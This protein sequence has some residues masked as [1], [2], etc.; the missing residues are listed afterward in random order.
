MR[1][2][3]PAPKDQPDDWL[4]VPAWALRIRRRRKRLF[5]EGLCLG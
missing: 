1:I 4:T 3:Y 5:E 2:G